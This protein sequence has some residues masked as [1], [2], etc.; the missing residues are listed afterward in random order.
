M[1]LSFQFLDGRKAY[2]WANY[3]TE[4]VQQAIEAL[5]KGYELNFTYD[6][7]EPVTFKAEDI[8]Y[9]KVYL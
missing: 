9:I 1:K 3:T 6:D 5:S 2:G 8:D 4:Q 7:K